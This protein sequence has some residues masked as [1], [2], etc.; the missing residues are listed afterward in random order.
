MHS[1]TITCARRAAGQVRRLAARGD[2]A[3]A[4][5][6]AAEGAEGAQQ[7][8]HR[9]S[10][11]RGAGLRRSGRRGRRRHRPHGGAERRLRPD[12]AGR[13]DQP[14][15]RL[16]SRCGQLRRGAGDVGAA[17]ADDRRRRR[18]DEPRRHAVVGR[19]LADGPVDRGAVLLHAAGHLR[20]SDRD[21]VR[22]LA[23]RR[24]RLCGREPEARREV[25]GRRATSRTPSCR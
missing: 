2:R 10:R 6:R 9:R 24:R 18:I 1:S 8:Q 12:R 16:G 14:L 5:D 17:L 20:R 11:R 4:R 23:R 3:C 15:L 21:Q 13:A 22:L 19:G 7:P 25:V